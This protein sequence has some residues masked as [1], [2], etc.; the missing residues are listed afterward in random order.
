[1]WAMRDFCAELPY[2]PSWCAIAKHREPFTM[3][4]SN[5]RDP[6]VI[7]GGGL[8]CTVRSFTSQKKNTA[9][10]SAVLIRIIYM[11]AD[12]ALSFKLRGSRLFYEA[13]ALKICGIIKKCL[14]LHT[15]AP[16]WWNGRHEGLKIPWPLRLCGFESHFGH[17]NP[18]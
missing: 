4:M 13:S 1:M 8:R 14:P 12:T 18:L 2:L 6:Q 5:F 15:G 3:S 10:F 7:N 11:V 9:A 16:E 17:C